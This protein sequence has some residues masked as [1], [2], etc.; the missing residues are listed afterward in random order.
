MLEC[1]IIVRK[2]KKMQTVFSHIVQKRFSRVNEDVAT[3]ALS[4]ILQGSDSARNGMMKLLRGLATDL[5][6]L[7]FRTQQTEGNIRPDMWGFHHTEPRVFIENKFWAGLTD[8]QPV[9]YLKQLTAYTGPTVLLMIVPEAREHI[10]WRE[11]Q[12]RL[13]DEGIATSERDI[14][15]GITYSVSTE[16]GPIL[17]LTSWAK[18]LTILEFEVSDE[19]SSKS[20]LLQLRALC[21]AAD[22]QA[23]IPISAEEISD[24]RTSALVLQ[25]STIVKAS[26]DLAVSQGVMNI[27]KLLPQ[28]SWDRIGRYARISGEK[29]AGVWFGLHF[30]LWQRHGTTPLW[31]LFAQTNFGR[32]IE[33]RKLI[34]P[35]AERQGI[36]TVCENDEFAIA[37]EVATGEDKDLVV[38]L[39]VDQLREIADI[40]SILDSN[41]TETS[42]A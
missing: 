35:W 10:L 31:L 34:E 16:I 7:R 12:R 32:S 25:L 28:A 17:A 8:N 11:L 21:D 30:D 41:I 20:D 42:N 27:T 39:I 4:F 22:S 5:P 2:R 33:V 19:P 3:D 36:L 29:G 26:T 18:L 37:I 13:K 23:F 24:H 1:I 40:L 6:D 9:A 38:S 15:T 14:A